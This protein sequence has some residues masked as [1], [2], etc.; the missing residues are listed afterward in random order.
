MRFCLLFDYFYYLFIGSILIYLFIYLGV[1][2]KFEHGPEKK[3]KMI[4][5]RDFQV[6]TSVNEMNLAK[7]KS[8]FGHMQNPPIKIILR[9]RKVY[10]WP[11][12]SIHTFCKN[13]GQ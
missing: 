9:M 12:L 7:Q 13:Q 2:T 1:I 10:S 3:K 6:L 11:F 5:M 4:Q 8:T